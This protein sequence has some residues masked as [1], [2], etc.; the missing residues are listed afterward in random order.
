MHFCKTYSLFKDFTHKS[1]CLLSFF[2][3]SPFPPFSYS[4]A[5]L[6]V[7]Q[8]AKIFCQLLKGMI[9][10]VCMKKKTNLLRNS[11]ILLRANIQSTVLEAI[12]N[13]TLAELFIIVCIFLR[14]T[15]LQEK[16]WFT[17]GNKL[18]IIEQYMFYLVII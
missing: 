12:S 16:T 14:Q 9:F 17:L 1:F 3:S 11:A 18:Y 13:L 7:C 10:S 2:L 5:D 15:H 8:E 6:P 4:L